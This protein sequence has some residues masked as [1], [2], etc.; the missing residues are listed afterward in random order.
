[1]SIDFYPNSDYF[2]T[3]SISNEHDTGIRFW[4]L[5][6][7]FEPVHLYDLTGGHQQC[8]NAVKFAPNGQYLASGSDDQIVIVW[9]LKMTPV[10]F[11]QREETV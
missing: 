7:T 10:E 9:S 5:K 4:K 3:S 6:S 2:V 8:V 1:M 11:G